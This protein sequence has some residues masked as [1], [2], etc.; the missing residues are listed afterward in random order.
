MDLQVKT[1]SSGDQRT[2]EALRVT[3]ILE[4]GGIPCCFCGVAAL[5][6]YGAGRVKVAWE[7]CV[8]SDLLKKAETLLSLLP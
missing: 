6:Y 5:I 4:S 2:L 8:P 7:I 3:Q 1:A